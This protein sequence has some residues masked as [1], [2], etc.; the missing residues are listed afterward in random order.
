MENPADVIDIS[1]WN[2][3]QW[4]GLIFVAA[5]GATLIAGCFVNQLRASFREPRAEHQF[6]TKASYFNL[7]PVAQCN[8]GS[9]E[10][11][12]TLPSLAPV[13]EL[14]GWVWC[15]CWLESSVYACHHLLWASMGGPDWSLLLQRSWRNPEEIASPAEQAVSKERVALLWSSLTLSLRWQ[16]DP[17]VCGC[18]CA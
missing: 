12:C 14:I 6:L 4:A 9:P 11:V 10:A 5:S 3:G 13:W 7:S 8:I 1:S 2:S 17:K 18:L 15:G 16:A